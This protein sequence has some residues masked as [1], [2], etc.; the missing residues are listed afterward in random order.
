M[1]FQALKSICWLFLL[2]F[3][4]IFSSKSVL[5]IS[6]PRLLIT[7]EKL[8]QVKDKIAVGKTKITYETML[9]L[10]A[11]SP[12]KALDKAFVYYVKKS[13]GDNNYGGLKEAKV[14]LLNYIRNANNEPSKLWEYPVKYKQGWNATPIALLYDW[15]FP[16]LTPVEQKE[17]R[18]YLIKWITIFNSYLTPESGLYLHNNQYTSPAAALGV[19][20]MT[21]EGES[22]VPENLN[23]ITQK[24]A[25]SFKSQFFTS[26]INPKGNLGEGI[27]YQNLSLPVVTVYAACATQLG[28]LD[29]KTTNAKNIF[30]WF[31]YA[32]ISNKEFIEY[33]DAGQV[34]SIWPQYLF[35]TDYFNQPQD[36]ATWNYYQ[37]EYPITTLWEGIADNAFYLMFYNGQAPVIDLATF[38]K[39]EFFYDKED[40]KTGGIVIMR[41]GFNSN[42]TIVSFINRYNY[43]IHQHYDPNSVSLSYRGKRFLIDHN[44]LMPYTNPDHGADFEHNLVVV[45]GGGSPKNDS[46]WSDDVAS[47]GEI[48]IFLQYKN[49]SL[50]IGDARYPVM[51]LSK[52]WNVNHLV[53]ETKLTTF[54]PAVKANR[55][56]NYLGDFFISPLITII[57]DYQ[58]DSQFHTYSLLYHFDR[59]TGYSGSGRLTDPFI[60]E[61]DNDKLVIFLGNNDQFGTVEHL[62]DL[63]GGDTV[64][65]QYHNV[66]KVKKNTVNAQFLTF[67]LPT[68]QTVPTIKP[69]KENNVTGYQINFGDPDINMYYYTN[70]DFKDLTLHD[71]QTDGQHIFI[72]IKK[73]KPT[74]V[75]IINYLKLQYQHSTIGEQT[76]RERQSIQIMF[77]NNS[78]A[79]RLTDNN[80]TSKN[81]EGNVTI[82]KVEG[83]VTGDINNDGKLDDNDYRIWKCEYQGNGECFL[84]YSNKTADLNTNGRVDL[85]DFEIWRENITN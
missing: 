33:G 48:V 82:V 68:S 84:P 49:N 17:I 79:G 10:S 77:N 58:V 21:V 57:D 72:G 3:F 22:G 63:E 1:R 9:N 40:K 36:W 7:Q 71:F 5:A 47:Y 14:F 25:T 2:V 13:L 59:T 43:H 61:K 45:D 41:N 24:I 56:V 67:L 12:N 55:V 37:P 27:W 52:I 54:S 50:A 35:Y 81:V 20:L 6:H 8:N 34:S 38:P 30:N 73:G 23:A 32:G 11:N 42:N 44:G 78:Y 29:L 16:I 53:D 4:I 18:D 28:Y 74:L 64:P 15:T 80:M 65:E 69:I 60:M 39:S 70:N 31:L 76:T 62:S 51:D 46:G 26:A 75:N 66:I 83:V 19:I 85:V